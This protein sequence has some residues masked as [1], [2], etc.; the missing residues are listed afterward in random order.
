[1]R[2]AMHLLV[3]LAVLWCGLHL[4]PA[5]ADESFGADGAALILQ[6]ADCEGDRTDHELPHV[7]HAGH[8]HCPVASDDGRGPVLTDPFLAEVTPFAA[9]PKVLTSRSQAPPI[10]PPAA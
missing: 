2:R 10:E 8:S 4:S 3:A 9:S 6:D 5:E 1:M 7:A